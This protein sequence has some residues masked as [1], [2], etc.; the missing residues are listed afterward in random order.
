MW[1]YRPLLLLLPVNY[2]LECQTLLSTVFMRN[3]VFPFG[4]VGHRR[5]DSTSFLVR[6]LAT[7]AATTGELPF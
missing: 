1:S 3:V 6:L 5:A 7:I 4:Y 2:R